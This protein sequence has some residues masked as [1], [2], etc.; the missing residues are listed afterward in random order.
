MY[1]MHVLGLQT[2]PFRCILAGRKKE[3]KLK[4]YVNKQDLLI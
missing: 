3:N 2:I 4:C 1:V